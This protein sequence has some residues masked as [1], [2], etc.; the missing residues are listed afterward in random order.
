M[1]E[2]TRLR[3]SQSKGSELL[4]AARAP[5]PMPAE[6]RAR[7]A[8][9]VA[10]LAV[11]PIAVGATAKWVSGKTI[12]WLLGF[13]VLGAAIGVGAYAMRGGSGGVVREEPQTGPS[14]GAD[15]SA[16]PSAGAGASAG[17]SAGPSASSSAGA[18]ASASGIA[19]ASP[20]P[21]PPPK[22]SA[23]TLAEENA[24]LD[25]VRGQ[26]ESDPAG[27]LGVADAHRKKFPGG[28]LAADREY[29]AVRAL[30]KLGREDE[31]K[32]RGAAF[33]VKYP[34]SPYAMYVRRLIE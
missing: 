18:S 29:L 28:Q 21:S 6:V 8:A 30:K 20:T 7:S 34:N 1:N 19:P 32:K 4:R 23:D 2:P 33:L 12:A 11:T 16:S 9:R 27:V 14:A 5:R 17:A 25:P 31:A 22:A 10:A 24:L 15:P 13:G 3:D 26:L